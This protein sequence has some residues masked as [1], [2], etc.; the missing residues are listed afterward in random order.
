MRNPEKN[1]MLFIMSILKSPEIEYNANNLAKHLNLSAMGVLKIA[2]RLIKQNIS[3]SRK[4]GKAI[5]YKINLKNEYAQHYVKFLLKKEAEQTSPYIKVW[6]NEI[7]KIRNADLAILFGSVLKKQ[8]EAKD[9]DVLFVT[10]NEKFTN[11]KKEI[12]EINKI[13]PKKIHPIYQSK[14]DLEKNIKKSDKIILSSIK[15][16]TI[17]GEDLFIQILEK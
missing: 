2:R 5:I 16:I 7:K 11:L 17:Y 9:I 4:I 15:G 8:K 6:I 13:N 14:E 12:E 1:E 10:E 3:I